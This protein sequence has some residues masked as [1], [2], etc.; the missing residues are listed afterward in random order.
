MLASSPARILNHNRPPLGILRDSI[1][2]DYALAHQASRTGTLMAT[3]PDV[4][5]HHPKA[6]RLCKRQTR[7]VELVGQRFA[8]LRFQHPKGLEVHTKRVLRQSGD[9]HHRNASRELRLLLSQSEPVCHSAELWKGTS[10]HLAHEICPMHLHRRFG[11][12]D[13]VGNLFV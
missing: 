8:K 4:Q 5:L 2:V 13:A 12:A 1:S 7:L 9:L 11:D 3:G 6:C 10:L